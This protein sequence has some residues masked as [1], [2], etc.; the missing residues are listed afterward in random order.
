[1]TQQF[2]SKVS[3]TGE[4]KTYPHKYLHLNVLSSTVFNAPK[5]ETKQIPID[6]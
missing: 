1:M 3:N 6:R 5:V 4:M 2:H